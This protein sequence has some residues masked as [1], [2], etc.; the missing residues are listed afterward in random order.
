VLPPAALSVSVIVASTAPSP[1][2]AVSPPPTLSRSLPLNVRASVAGAG[3]FTVNAFGSDPP[4]PLGL[5]TTT[6]RPPAVAAP[7]IANDAVRR[8]DETKAT[9]VTVISAPALT[10][11]PLANPLPSIVTGTV[12]PA[13]PWAGDTELT[14]TGTFTVNAIASDTGIPLGFRTPTARPPAS[15]ALSRSN[16]AVRRADE[17]KT[18]FLT[19]MPAPALTL[20]PLANPLPSIVTATVEPAVPCEGDTEL[21]TTGAATLTVN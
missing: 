17:T 5:M 15:T 6:A 16:D 2:S 13:M 3:T 21:T 10:V 11:A 20:A 12:E 7:S 19:V 18:T 8:V 14:V 9:F 4:M 1:A